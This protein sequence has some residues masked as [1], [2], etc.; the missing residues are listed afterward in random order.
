MKKDKMMHIIK[1]I[2]ILLA[3]GGISTIFIIYKDF[4][5]KF[6]F[7]FVVAYMLFLCA[8]VLYMMVISLLRLRTLKWMYIRKRLIRFIVI[9][10]IFSTLN[11]AAD[12]FFR[13][14]KIDLL[15]N[16]SVAF[17]SAFGISFFDVI[18]L[19]SKDVKSSID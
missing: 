3:I 7:R 13:P 9:F 17:G 1:A 14:E 10:V 11:Y 2:Y 6:T 16:M 8:S 5:N 12:Y 18:F 4:D 19:K 15:R